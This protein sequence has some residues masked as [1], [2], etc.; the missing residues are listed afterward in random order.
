MYYVL[1]KVYIQI[2]REKKE[3]YRHSDKSELFCLPLGTSKFS[4]KYYFAILVCFFIANIFSHYLSNQQN[5]PPHWRDFHT[6]TAVGHLMF[7]FGG[8][9][10]ESGPWYTNHEFYCNKLQILDTQINKWCCPTMSKD[11][12]VGRRSHSACKNPLIVFRVIHK[13]FFHL[14][15]HISS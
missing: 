10:D 2:K 7:V 5:E 11:V 3:D 14:K 15:R 12:P 1:K 9:S 6:A 4:R 8:R 13:I